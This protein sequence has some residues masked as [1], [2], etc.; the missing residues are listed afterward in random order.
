LKREMEAITSAPRCPYC[1]LAEREAAS[2]RLVFENEGFVL[3]APF[4]SQVPYETWILPKKHASDLGGL[5]LKGLA[6]VLG[7]ALRRLDL[8]LS[9]PP[10]NYMIS[11]L[12]DRRY[13]LNI[14]I[15]PAI[16]TMAGFEKNT[17]IFINTVQPETAA[18]QLREI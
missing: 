3:I 10:Y 17:G 5:D 9:G 6:E 15:K 18:R 4:W 13:H 8:L 14:K 12:P 16:S 11:Q 2:E 7:E 1:S